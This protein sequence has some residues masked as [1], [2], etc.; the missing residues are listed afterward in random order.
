MIKYTALRVNG[1]HTCPPGYNEYTPKKAL[2]SLVIYELG[3]GGVVTKLSKTCI[4]VR[5]LVMAC[6]DTTIFEGPEEEMA[7]LVE[8]AAISLVTNPLA[9]DA[10][11]AY[12]DAA[13]ASVM[14][15]TKGNVSLL[16][17]AGPM[18][19]GSIS[20]KSLMIIMIGGYE[21]INTFM[22]LET[23]DLMAILALIRLD[24]ADLK[25]VLTLMEIQV[26]N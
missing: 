26:V 13:M 23:K 6:I 12:T 21:Y 5:T 11:P 10:P 15:Q 7:L 16:T 25:D 22:T 18:I 9:D 19:L 14:S 3:F 24:G 8:A 2:E 1:G 17:M 4:E 20:I